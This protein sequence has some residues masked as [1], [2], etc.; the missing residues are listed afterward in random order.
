MMYFK[1]CAFCELK[2]L[3]RNLTQKEQNHPYY[4]THYTYLNVIMLPEN[5][6]I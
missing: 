5:I 6:F 1:L 3:N 2:S 4:T